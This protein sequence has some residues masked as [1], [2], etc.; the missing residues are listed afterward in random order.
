[1]LKHLTKQYKGK[2]WPGLGLRVSI[3]IE[4][5]MTGQDH[6]AGPFEYGHDVTAYID[7]YAKHHN[8][9]NVYCRGELVATTE[10]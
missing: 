10:Y 3:R 9:F 5:H 6:I 7:E 4:N 2:S 8:A 1:M